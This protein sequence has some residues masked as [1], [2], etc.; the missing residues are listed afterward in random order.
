MHHV[1]R[2]DKTEE[3]ADHIVE[4]LEGADSDYA[5]LGCGLV[6][7]RLMNIE[8]KLDPDEEIKWL[9]ALMEWADL[10]WAPSERIN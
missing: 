6:M 2:F 7:G 10:Y 8:R 3:A 5:I 9:Q 4:G 1:F